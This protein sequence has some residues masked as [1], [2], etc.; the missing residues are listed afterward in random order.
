MSKAL[1]AA[2]VLALAA[3]PAAAEV[4]ARTADSFTLSFDVNIETTPG[5]VV[6]ALENVGLWWDGA[7]TYS[8]EAT[9]LSLSLEPGGC[10]CEALP[11]GA[12]FEHGHVRTLDDDRLRLDAPLG[13]LKGKATRADLTF[14]WPETRQGTALTMTFVVEGPGLGALA[15]AVDGVMSGQFARLA[16]F[17]EY[18]EAS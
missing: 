2:V 6:L 13:P 14:S 10:L 3:T 8:G 9:N 7:H 1:I 4:V 12:T 17:V 11:D 5:D 18:G 16:R 15:D